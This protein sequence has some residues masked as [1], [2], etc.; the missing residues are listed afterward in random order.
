MQCSLEGTPLPETDTDPR[1]IVMLVASF[2]L[3]LFFGR[4]DT[5]DIFF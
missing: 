4:D 2:V 1:L 5:G 3:G